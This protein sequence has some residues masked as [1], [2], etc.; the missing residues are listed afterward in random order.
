MERFESEWKSADVALCGVDG[1]E[2]SV[3]VVSLER[4]EAAELSE[5]S[6]ELREEAEETEFDAFRCARNVD[7]SGAL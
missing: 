1:S 6:A 5:S 4:C 2:I 3:R 7:T